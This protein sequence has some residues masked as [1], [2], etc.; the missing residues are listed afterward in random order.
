[1][2]GGEI[3]HEARLL[4]GISQRELAER[5][6]VPR[7]SIVRWEKGAVEPGFD[8]VRRLLR[9]CGFD[10]SLVRYQRGE[11]GDERLGGKLELAPQERLLA[12]LGEPGAGI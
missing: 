2:T 4:A 11:I 3:I 1:M 8:T 6:A 5:A 9:S 7:Q 10:V 12:M